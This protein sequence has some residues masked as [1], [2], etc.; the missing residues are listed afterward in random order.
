MHILEIVPSEMPSHLREFYGYSEHP[1][2]KYLNCYCMAVLYHLPQYFDLF[3]EEIDHNIEEAKYRI[4]HS[5]EFVEYDPLRQ[6]TVTGD[7]VIYGGYVENILSRGKSY[8]ARH[9]QIYLSQD[10][11]LTKASYGNQPYGIE[12][13]KVIE[14]ALAWTSNYPGRRNQKRYFTK[15]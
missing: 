5:G 7:I 6:S 2:A 15:N 10:S 1:L 11:A 13:V 3:T 9:A 4:W 14:H 8:E 12:S